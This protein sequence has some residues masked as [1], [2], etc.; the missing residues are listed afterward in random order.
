MA[1]VKDVKDG[2]VKFNDGDYKLELVYKM[3]KL[4]DVYVEIGDILDEDG[5]PETESGAKYAVDE[6]GIAIKYSL[7]D[8]KYVEDENGI[9]LAKY[10]LMA[11]G[12]VM[13]MP[14]MENGRSVIDTEKSKVKIIREVTT[15][16][17]YEIEWTITANKLATPTVN[18]QVELTYNGKEQSAESILKGF[19]ATYMEIVEGGKGTNAGTYTAKIR[20]KAADT[21]HEWADPD[22]IIDEVGYVYVTWEIKKAD[23]DLSNAKWVFTD[24]TTEYEDGKGMIYTRKNGKAVVYWATLANLPEEVQNSIRYTTNGKVG[25]YAGTDAGRYETTFEIVGKEENFN[26]ITIPDTLAEV[27]QWTIQRRMLEIPT[28]LGSFKFIFDDQPHDLLAMLKL[29]DDYAE[30]FDIQVLYAKNFIVYTEYEGHN[31]NPY[32]AFGAGGYKFVFDILDG[33]NKDKKNPNVV[34]LKSNGNVE[35]PSVEETENTEAEEE[36]SETQ[37]VRKAPVV[38][39]VEEAVEETLKPVVKTVAKRVKVSEPKTAEYVPT[40]VEVVCDRLKNLAYGVQ[41]NSKKYTV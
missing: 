1:Y 11:D 39:A 25:A 17:P 31:G 10:K 23:V 16:D 7:V 40:E 30:Y 38:E 12:S 15:T 22:E 14:V 34:W 32:E 19:N 18:E 28:T 5:R 27:V 6:N 33:I 4:V 36:M 8:G 29:Q 41:L 35:V 9:Y 20:I 37:S 13:E 3:E 21:D 24:G 26:S 2:Y